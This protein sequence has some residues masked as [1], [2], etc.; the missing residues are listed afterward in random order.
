MN[1]DQ[2]LQALLSTTS[3]ETS[4]QAGEFLDGCTKTI[5][6]TPALLKF[7]VDQTIPDTVRHAAVIYLKNTIIKFWEKDD[8]D[9]SRK[10]ENGGF[11]LSDQDK[12]F[13][14]E[15]VVDA[16]CVAPDA[17]KVQLCTAVQH[18]VRADFPEQWVSLI[19]KVAQL[20]STPDGN[21]WQGALL[22]VYKVAKVYEYRRAKVRTPLIEAMKLLLPTIHS[23]F[24][25]L[26]SN[27]S[28]E[29]VVIQKIILKIMFA[30][31]QFSLNL[32][33]LPVEA[34]DGW[35]GG[36]RQ[37]IVRPVPAEL[38]SVEDLDE[39][40]QMVWWKCKKWACKILERVFDRYGAPGQVE[41][42]YAEFAQH[43]LQ[44]FAVPCV[45]AF[46]NILEAKRQG[47]FV[48][49]RVLHLA[50]NFLNTAVSHSHTWKVIKP[51]MLEVV[52][53]V[54][55]PL[56]CHS[57]EDE[58]MW[59]DDVQEYIRFKFD[60]FEDLHN[61]SYASGALLTA[62]SK[63]K[64]TMQ[65]IL[66]F[67]IHILAS[68]Q[69]PREIDGALHMV[70]ELANQLCKSKKYKKDVEKLLDA[71]V[72]GRLTDGARFVRARAAWCLKTFSSTVFQHG[73]ILKKISDGLVKRLCDPTEESPCKVESALGIQFLL[74][75]QG[76][77]MHEIAKPYVKE[78]IPKV[79]ELVAQ[80][81]IEDICGVMDQLIEDFM[82]D[83]IPI[84][85][86]LAEQL[87]ALFLDVVQQ[88]EIADD[89]TPTLMSIISTLTNIL[90]V[91]EEHREIMVQVEGHVLRIIK[92][93]FSTSNVDYYDDVLMLIQ[94]LTASYISE[95]M[96]EV[97]N[98]VY[99]MF[100]QDNNTLVCF[101][102]VMPCLHQY[103]TVDTEAFLARPERLNATLEMCQMVLQDADQGDDN[104]LHAAKLLEC[105]L[106][107][108]PG[109]INSAVPAIMMLSLQRLTQPFEGLSELKPMLILVL[110][111]AIYTNC[112]QATHVLKEVAPNH[113][114]PLD[115]ITEEL[116]NLSDK[117]EGVHDR[118]MAVL[119]WCR[120]LQLPPSQ[121]PTIIGYQPNK[122]IESCVSVFEG[123]EKAIKAQADNARFDEEESDDE[124][125]DDD[126]NIGSSKKGSKSHNK[127]RD[128]DED[129]GDS[130]DE[131]DESTLEYLESLAKEH[132]KHGA[133]DD[134]DESD[135]EEDYFCDE[136]ETE[137]Y[138]TPL[139]EETAPDVF[140]IFKK[141]MEA[142]EQHEPT[143]F[144]QMVGTLD[145]KGQEGL[146]KLITVCA[147][148][149]QLEESKKVEQQGGYNFGQ[150]EVPT[151]FNFSG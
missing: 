88:E 43:F 79:L 144:Q 145:Q 44:K 149:A 22:V 56:M 130:E 115:Y 38:D 127:H 5:G 76:D 84:A 25:Q 90:D 66:G 45:E 108:C 122:V 143:L 63:R 111:A 3:A 73:Y 64:D 55:F 125:D 104:Q 48:S 30:L 17:A 29:S 57:D 147:Q 19:P 138:T 142:F 13:I 146:Q 68:S 10:Q 46:L 58:E 26:L 123:L 47:A 67:V 2:I 114:N 12:H 39:R 23:H 51:H 62:I 119:A 89:R 75:D 65:P 101:T 28:Q 99:N 95:P 106:L 24:T 140:V 53:T 72:V 52:K 36:I 7:V 118:K 141:T 116:M 50:I 105:V 6:F 102:D 41:S 120:L 81:Q 71:H 100:K 128:M 132:K 124:S 80:T 136:T 37:V 4:K 86:Q 96:W 112:E 97:F 98:D 126:T 54:L 8:D 151:N 92:V 83:V 20:L 113:P 11:S 107:Q 35:L 121:R 85:A 1:R 14:R 31:V 117:W 137:M 129:L 59:E 134:N 135:D 150:G 94:S 61:P 27:D 60:I 103:V 69:N 49:D 40:A 131:I 16:V 110:V 70:G 9:E 18:I 77:K 42:S 87:S 82:E 15:H 109:V 21:S 33:M 74:N 148:H 93:V 32:E 139:D 91:V 133:D 78:I 34:L